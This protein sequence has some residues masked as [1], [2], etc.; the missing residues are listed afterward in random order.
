MAMAVTTQPSRNSGFYGE[1]VHV[2]ATIF[3]VGD[4]FF[5]W[6]KCELSNDGSAG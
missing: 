1:L 3:W 5:R 2:E 4:M 6:K